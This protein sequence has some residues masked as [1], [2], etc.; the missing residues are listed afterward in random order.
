MYF[1]RGL[2]TYKETKPVT[3]DNYKLFVNYTASHDRQYNV[4]DGRKDSFIRI[5]D[6]VFENIGY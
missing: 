1:C 3:Y 5:M 2:I 6:S 4:T